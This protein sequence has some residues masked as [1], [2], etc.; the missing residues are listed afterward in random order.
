[1]APPAPLVLAVSPAVVWS[2]GL[3]PSRRP[4]AGTRIRSSRG[5]PGPTARRADKRVPTS[6]HYVLRCDVRR[7]FA[8]VIGDR[9][10]VDR[11]HAVSDTHAIPNW[12]P[13]LEMTS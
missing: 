8:S 7:R 10:F 13:R 1:M 12:K 6:E 3:P 4:A 11:Y 2:N 5:R 9:Q